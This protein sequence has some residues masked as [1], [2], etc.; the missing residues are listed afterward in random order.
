MEARRP[1]ELNTADGEY[2]L[3]RPR[4]FRRKT[5]EEE[6]MEDF[7]KLVS[8]FMSQS[9][10]QSIFS[11]KTP[12]TESGSELLSA[13]LR[14]KSPKL[15]DLYEEVDEEA[16]GGFNFGALRNAEDQQMRLRGIGSDT[17]ESGVSHLRLL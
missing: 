9:T 11:M 17:N 14:R 10:D 7:A 8:V 3:T 2:P 15:E 12:D 16:E 5:L 4:R 6:E 1:P 13:G